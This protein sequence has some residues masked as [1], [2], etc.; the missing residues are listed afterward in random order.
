MR[1][2]TL[3]CLCS[4]LIPPLA[5]A[6]QTKAP[7]VWGPY[8]FLVGTW[9]AEGHG[10]PG[11]GEGAFSF[12]LELQGKILVRKNHL[13]FP[14]TPQRSAFTHEDLLIVYRDADA[15]PNRA[16]YFDSEGFVIH[17]TATFSEQGKVLTFLSEASPQAPRQRLTYVQDA[18]GTVKVKFEI[19]PPGKPE[20]FVTH[21]EGIAHREAVR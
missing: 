4:L 10:E 11:K 2:L 7:D 9:T 3:L 12:Q 13:E 19:A 14:A 6:Q 20:A 8:K 16:I 18:D 5:A 21:V 1:R 15:T 17:Y